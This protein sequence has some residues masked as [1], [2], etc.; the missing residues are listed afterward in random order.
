V[1]YDKLRIRGSEATDTEWT[2]LMATFLSALA[3]SFGFYQEWEQ[4][5][6]DLLWYQGTERKPSVVIEHESYWRSKIAAVVRKLLSFRAP[7]RVLV[8]YL[9]PPIPVADAGP[10]VRKILN[11]IERSIRSSRSS[12]KGEFVVVI[13]GDLEE[14]QDWVA[15]AWDEERKDWTPLAQSPP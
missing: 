13:G 4:K 10:P 14:P 8:T 11:A 12:R 6:L 7:L 9:W 3:S 1:Y 5:R 15:Y 2:H